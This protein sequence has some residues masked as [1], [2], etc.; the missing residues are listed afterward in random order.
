MEQLKTLFQRHQTKPLESSK[1]AS[2]DKTLSVV[3]ISTSLTRKL[4]AAVT[5]LL[6]KVSENDNLDKSPPVGS[7]ELTTCLAQ[8]TQKKGI[9]NG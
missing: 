6:E 9:R 7:V 3:Q 4:K 8:Q 5:R 1:K 2:T